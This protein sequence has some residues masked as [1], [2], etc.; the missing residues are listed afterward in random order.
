[1]KKMMMMT[2]MVHEKR[3]KDSSSYYYSS[4]LPIYLSLWLLFYFNLCH[5]F[6]LQKSLSCT[7]TTTTAAII[8]KTIRYQKMSVLYSYL[9]PEKDPEYKSMMKKSLWAPELLDD[10][11][12][13]NFLPSP[14]EGDILLCPGLW[15]GEKVLGL[16]RDVIYRNDTWLAEV[17]PLKEGKSNSVYTIDKDAKYLEAPVIDT[18]PVKAFFIRAENAYNI[19]TVVTMK[20]GKNVSEPILRAPGYRI[21]DTTFVLPKKSKVCTYVDLAYVVIVI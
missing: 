18:A 15:Q 4:S 11:G 14:K 20:D 9:P 21:L 2:S 17:L 8:H 16:L 12:D 7:T 3:K 13:I 5:G 19:S 1:M 6:V 10:V